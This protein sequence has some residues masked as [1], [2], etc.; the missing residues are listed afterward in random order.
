MDKAEIRKAM[1]AAKA[2]LAPE[3]KAEAAVRCFARLEELPEF[4]NA[5]SILLYA[6]LPDELSTSAFIQRW[7]SHK[8]ICLPRVNGNNLEILPYNPE[9]LAKGA[10]GIN[11]PQGNAEVNPS[12][13][14]L[15]VVPGVAFDSQGNRLGRG[16]G[17]YDRL[18]CQTKAAKIGVAYDLQV[19]DRLPSEPH[20]VLM[21][22]IVTESR[23]LG[24]FN[25]Q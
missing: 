24:P 18:L 17:F 4:K 25:N 13:I 5:Q 3:Q 6:S 7:H 19:V 16:R 9:E 12:E 10:F 20:D 14:D 8:R 15:I 21:D 2:K 11:E 1:K 23:T 22:R